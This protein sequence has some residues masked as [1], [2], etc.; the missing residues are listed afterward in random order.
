M[1]LVAIGGL[2]GSL[3]AGVLSPQLMSISQGPS[4]ND[5]LAAGFPL[6]VDHKFALKERSGDAKLNR[7]SLQ[8]FE[9]TVVDP[10]QHCE[11]CTLL[12]YTPGALKHAGIGYVGNPVDLL[13]AKR[14]TVFVMGEEGGELVKLAI[15]GKKM[16]ASGE[17]KYALKTNTIT[18]S[19]EW[20]P[21]QIDLTQISNKTDLLGVTHPFEIEVIKSKTEANNVYIKYVTYDQELAQSPLETV[22][23]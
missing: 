13:E 12:R 9:Q 4:K 1:L 18:L 8:V 16:Q 2:I 5:A 7:A 3:F 14:M 21:I 23:Q 20:T 19:N 10:D 15:A 6:S 17:V 11:Y 22:Q